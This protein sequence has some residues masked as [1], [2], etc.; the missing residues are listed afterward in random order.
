MIQ[1]IDTDAEDAMS[2]IDA[3]MKEYPYSAAR[4]LNGDTVEL[5]F[6]ST[7]LELQPI[8]ERMNEKSGEVTSWCK[9]N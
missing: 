8:L 6:A 7:D 3:A 5:W 9:P 1:E 2:Q 4:F